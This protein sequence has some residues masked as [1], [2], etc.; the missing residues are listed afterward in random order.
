MTHLASVVV[1]FSFLP[2]LLSL[3]GLA[4]GLGTLL[5]LAFVTLGALL[6]V[7]L[8][9]LPGLP[10]LNLATGPAPSSNK[11]ASSTMV[12]TERVTLKFVSPCTMLSG[13]PGCRN[14]CAALYQLAA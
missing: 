10:L 6:D 3:Q 13:S 7:T 1:L 2:A 5:L 8:V 12:N 4:L 11:P 9:A 14:Y